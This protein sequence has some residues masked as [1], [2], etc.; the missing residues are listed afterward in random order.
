MKDA[1]NWKEKPLLSTKEIA[2]LLGVNE[3]TVRDWIRA[4]YLKAIKIGPRLWRVRTSDF[5][6]IIEGGL[7]IE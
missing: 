2:R 3:E 7:S 5:L 6:K 4:G 1:W